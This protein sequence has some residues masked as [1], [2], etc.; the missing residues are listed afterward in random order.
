MATSFLRGAAKTICNW[1][2]I[3][4]NAHIFPRVFSPVLFRVSC[5]HHGH[6]WSHFEVQGVNLEKVI[7]QQNPP[8]RRFAP[9]K[10]FEF[11]DQKTRRT[12]KNPPIQRV[13]NPGNKK[14]TSCP[15]T[16][17]RRQQKV[18]PLRNSSNLEISGKWPFQRRKNI[19]PVRGEQFFRWKPL[20]LQY[21]CHINM[22]GRFFV[23]GS[24]SK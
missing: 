16:P 20:G 6:S 4:K 18:A 11:P 21:W 24:F 23:E 13:R 14:T 2:A 8:P 9:T 12:F 19:G 15:P 22:L 7:P 5:E 17:L 3:R 1:I 10:K